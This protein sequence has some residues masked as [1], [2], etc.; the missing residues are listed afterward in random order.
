MSVTAVAVDNPTSQPSNIGAD[1]NGLL[2][3]LSGLRAAQAGLDITAQNI[4]NSG[5]E[6]FNR[7]DLVLGQ[8]VMSTQ[9]QTGNG[10]EVEA[11]RRLRS[12]V[13]E[14]LITRNISERGFAEARLETL[15]SVETLLAP[16]DGSLRDRLSQF[17]SSLEELSARS[18][19]RALRRLVVEEGTQLTGQLNRLSS[20]VQ[21]LRYSVDLQIETAVEEFNSLAERAAEFQID[22]LQKTNQ[23][24]SLNVAKDEYERVVNRLAD[25]VDAQIDILQG[26]ASIVRFASGSGV[27]GQKP[28][29][30]QFDIEGDDAVIK[31]EGRV[32]N[33]R[34]GSGRLGGLLDSRNGILTQFESDLDTIA[35]ELAQAI[36]SVHA[37]GI[38]Q[39]GSFETLAGVRGLT[40]TTVPLSESG[41]P[42]PLTDGQLQVYITDTAT[43]VGTLG[44]V[45]VDVS[46]D[47]LED[48]ADRLGQIP[49]V[50][51]LINTSGSL[52]ISTAPGYEF[53]FTGRVETTPDQ[54]LVTGSSAIRLEGKF[55]GT[56][57]DTWRF[58]A[59]G[60]G[61][62]GQA[63]GLF[64][65]V[66]NSEGD[67]VT[68]LDL[69]RGYEP[70]SRLE[71]D[72]GVYA[73]FSPGDLNAGDEFSSDIVGKSDT[74]GLLVGLGLNTFFAGSGAGNLS[75]SEALVDDPARFAN[76]VT[77][78]GSDSAV[79]NKMV[80]VRKSQ[81]S[82][83]GSRTVEQSL[84][85]LTA[86]IGADT[87]SAQGVTD[88]LQLASDQLFKDR[89]GV[90]GVDPNEELVRMLAY[91]RQFQ[92]S[93]T[94]IATM[95][96]TFDELFR[97]I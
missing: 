68:R 55:G 87:E 91:Q 66:R 4:A 30:L 38:G 61:Q 50:N 32:G 24:E 74:T 47:S 10:V 19:D 65:D 29:K 48:V 26:G 63:E 6:G 96:T 53:D 58:E 17:F 67:L 88:N 44:R 77:S 80:A 37:E 8:K 21:E 84:G 71:I 60:S 9:S 13:T 12:R 59:V 41:S 75:V 36:D 90:S 79:L 95:R 92:A 39:T 46:V 97:I 27:I 33:L 3:G 93:S 23:Q 11:I 1:M 20:L 16:I 83:N 69:G 42:F 62:I 89:E 51:A 76:G 18:G 7:R 34:I 43:G 52:I 73:T 22:V 70:G 15:N 5:S 56:E 14:E 85:D 2:T 86:L 54:S 35:R 81:I 82:D 78:E 57:N 25:S 64:V 28:P 45:D 94:V 49:N 72:S 40:D 31:I